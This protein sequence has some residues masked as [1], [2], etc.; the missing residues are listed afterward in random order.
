MSKYRQRSE[1]LL[2]AIVDLR[3][4]VNKLERSPRLAYSTVDPDQPLKLMGTLQ[5]FGSE[6]Q[7]IAEIGSVGGI[8]LKAQSGETIF[9]E[10]LA[11]AG[12]SKPYGTYNFAPTTVHTTPTVSTSSASFVSQWTVMGEYL[13]E[14]IRCVLRVQTS[15]GTTGGDIQLVNPT[16][17]VG[18][19]AAP[20]VLAS[21]IIAL[22]DARYVYLDGDHLHP[23]GN[24]TDFRYDIQIRRTAGAGSI[25]SQLIYSHGWGT[26]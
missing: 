5:V 24:P 14:K 22:G 20:R 6:G 7:L 19:P 18:D 8:K 10:G 1:D 3:K 2:D 26:G 15:D 16:D 11:G 25:L 23:I 13:H 9:A 17:L 4:R 21:D 12:L